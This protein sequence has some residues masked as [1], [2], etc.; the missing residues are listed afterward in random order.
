MV[1]YR[2]LSFYLLSL[3]FFTLALG[4]TAA[5]DQLE[6][7]AL[8]PDQVPSQS[9]FKLH[10]ADPSRGGSLRLVMRL[11]G[12]NHY[13]LSTSDTFGRQLWDLELRNTDVMILD[14]KTHEFCS[15]D[16]A[17]V[18]SLLA[19]K[20]LSLESLPLVLFGRLPAQ[21]AEDLELSSTSQVFHDTLGQKWSVRGQESD[22]EAW[23]LWDI[24]RPQ[25]WWIRHGKGGILSGR[26][27]TQIRWEVASVE[28]L[29]HQI[30]SLTIP[31]TYLRRP[32]DDADLSQFREDQSAPS[33]VGTQR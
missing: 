18:L 31:E 8:K 7:W 19:L 9:I 13:E 14:H 26:N 27:G 28:P 10:Y 15:T 2:S 17:T 22:P 30:E 32:C 4:T 23:T 3:L 25:L 5:A 29:A 6:P 11:A 16:D 24:D 1:G 20:P 21:P 33:G 12:A